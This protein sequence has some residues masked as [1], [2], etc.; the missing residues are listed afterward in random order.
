[1][2]ITLLKQ[3]NIDF[4]AVNDGNITDIV[5]M[6]PYKPFDNYPKNC[7]VIDS[8]YIASNALYKKVAEIEKVVCD[9]GFTLVKRP[10][11]LKKIAEQGGLGTVL[12]NM[13]LVNQKY[14]SKVTLQGL[15][16]QGKFEYIVNEK[17]DKICPNCRACDKTCPNNA[18]C[19]GVFTRENC[20]RHKQDFSKDYFAVIGNRVLGCSECQKVCPYN[21]HI[22]SEV[23]PKAVQQIFDYKNIFDMIKNG[24]KELIPLANLIG[25]NMARPTFIFNLMVNC[26]LASHNFEYTDIIGTFVSSDN[27]NISAKAKFYLEN[28]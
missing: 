11:H 4:C 15:S 28:I 25:S 2:L 1:M 18:L 13:L 10:L 9:S 12:D 20:I 23:M 27:K 5:F 21:N 14:G 6:M 26:L 22:G 19:Q 8:F 17:V 7:A 3:Y 16:V 24:R